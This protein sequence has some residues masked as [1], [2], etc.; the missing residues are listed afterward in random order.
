[1]SPRRLANDHVP[2]FPWPGVNKVSC[3]QESGSVPPHGIPPI[4]AGL[5]EAGATMKYCLTVLLK[6]PSWKE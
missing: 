3:P 5:T 2:E 1:M 4:H 6:L